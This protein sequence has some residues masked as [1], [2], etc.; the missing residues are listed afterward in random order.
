M[1]KNKIYGVL[2]IG[3]W[4]LTSLVPMAA[5]EKAKEN[6]KKPETISTTPK[7]VIGKL[8]V[9]N[10]KPFD[11]R[12]RAVFTATTLNADDTLAG[13][14]TFIIADPD[15]KRVAEKLGKP[16]TNI[17]ASVSKKETRVEFEKGAHCPELH[18][19]LG[20]ENVE[21]ADAPLQFDRLV[22]TFN[23]NAQELSKLLCVLTRQINI[24][25]R[26]GGAIGRIKIVLNG[27]EEADKDSKQPPA[28]GKETSGVKK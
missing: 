27:G 8:Q 4:L 23:E 28:P 20:A 5:Q 21:L 6:A 12:V 2:I 26:P 3:L 13:I 9:V 1:L 24:G 18:I 15:R 10:S 14:L 16:L 19:V 17:P 11:L 7:L 25:R 22:L